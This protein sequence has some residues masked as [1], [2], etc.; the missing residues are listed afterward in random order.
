LLK[1]QPRSIRAHNVADD[2]QDDLSR[3][4]TADQ[5]HIV[6]EYEGKGDGNCEGAHL[7]DEIVSEI[8]GELHVPPEIDSPD[9]LHAVQRRS[10]SE[11]SYENNCSRFVKE[12][13]GK[14]CGYKKRK[15]QNAI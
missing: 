10:H 7:V 4:D 8:F 11:N 9:I 6:P 15:R 14:R 13:V 3:N 5:G 2:Y 1:R 12:R